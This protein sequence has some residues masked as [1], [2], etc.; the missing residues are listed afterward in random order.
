MKINY[1]KSFNLRRFIGNLSKK[2]KIVILASLVIAAMV[3]VSF[4]IIS[5]AADDIA[6]T[7]EA[8]SLNGGA[9]IDFDS[10]NSNVVVNNS[11]KLFSGYA[12]SEDLG[13]IAFG[14]ADNPLGPVSVD[15]G[16]G[17]VSGKARII[18]TDSYIDFNANPYHSNVTINSDGVFE[19]FAFSEDLGWIDFT[20]NV[21]AT[22][23]TLTT[24]GEPSNIRI[25]DV[26]DRDL[27]DYALV[28]RWQNPAV[29][30]E[31]N[32]LAFLVERSTDGVAWVQVASTTSRGYMD[33]NVNTGTTYY[34]RVKTQNTTGTVDVSDT[35]SQAPTGRYTS[36]CA[37]VSGP[38]AVI[39]PSSVE[40][41]W[42]TDRVCD[43]YLKIIELGVEFTT[44]GLTDQVTAHRVSAIGLKPN[45][46]YKYQVLSTDVDGNTLMGDE[47]SF[48]TTNSPS[49][50][51]LNISN[52]TLDSAI[53]NFKSTTI[54]NFTLHFG[55]T[56][57]Y[58]E[59]LSESSS[60]STTNHS[61]PLSD[62]ESGTIYYYRLLGEDS[63]G[64]EL[65]SENS[66][67]T[68][69][70]P[71]ITDFQ[72]EQ[73]KDQPT[74]TLKTTWK[75]N[76]GTSS[77]LKYGVGE[78]LLESS[79]SDMVTDHEITISELLDNSIYQ[80]YPQGRDQFGN[81]TEGSNVTFETPEDS[82]A[83][84]IFDFIT[85]T[86]N[87][88]NKSEK[89]QVIVSW[90]TDEPSTSAIEYGTGIDSADYTNKTT[91]DRSLTKEH[92]VIITDL[93][94]GVPYHLRAISKDDAGNLGESIPSSIVTGEVSESA[95]KLILNI[96]L[97]IFGWMSKIFN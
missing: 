25:F 1:F 86:S 59:T 67:S 6:L 40:V 74:T 65:K 45:H 11:T 32:F 9:K 69:P 91:E 53:V 82:R 77:I 39:G 48:A 7:G 89:S 68:L 76:V 87:V 22:G 78:E 84:K 19:G 94:P 97:G 3:G 10:Y 46:T 54:A 4:G 12:W 90:K 93:E 58:A 92:L 81:L 72:I 66:F 51:D 43:S 42:V 63:L 36:P 23:I 27:A 8:D 14:V 61:L 85:E 52:I 35:V 57:D 33:T 70:L 21:Q 16:S 73:V 80:L 79:S 31:A 29:F 47:T 88:G 96:L 50:Y 64:N 75:T 30:D 13:W 5:A 38:E 71:E 95:M 18:A 34:Y 60:S 41:T 2:A 49:I 37:L 44:Q 24:P 15:G 56:T 62:L 55:K 28:I 17:T 26:S 20:Y 83:P